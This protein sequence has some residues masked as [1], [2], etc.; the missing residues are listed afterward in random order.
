M[1]S[2]GTIPSCSSRSANTILHG[3]GPGGV[4]YRPASRAP[5][6]VVRGLCAR[7]SLAAPDRED[8]LRGR[9]PPAA[10]PDRG[11][12]CGAPRCRGPDCQAHDLVAVDVLLRVRL[13][14]ACHPAGLLFAG[15]NE[16]GRLRSG[17]T[18][19]KRDRRCTRDACAL[20]IRPEA[21]GARWRTTSA[22]GP[23]HAWGQREHQR[24]GKRRHRAR[25]VTCSDRS[26]LRDGSN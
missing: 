24:D 13:N 18:P 19:A 26:M 4:R 5:D 22:P 11:S 20:G 1:A 3:T 15:K 17:S 7:C 25:R 16:I 14:S 6:H 12:P 10:R 9:R 23:G 21:P 2:R 8:G